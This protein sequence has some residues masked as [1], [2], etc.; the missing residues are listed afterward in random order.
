M[1]STTVQIAAMTAGHAAQVLAIHQ[2]GIAAVLDEAQHEVGR[3]GGEPPLRLHQL[4]GALAS[5]R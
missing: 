5:R 1:T 3:L 2:L 4:T